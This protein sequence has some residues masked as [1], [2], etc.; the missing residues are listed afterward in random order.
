MDTL[1]AQSAAPTPSLRAVPVGFCRCV[2]ARKCD[3]RKAL[4]FSTSRFGAK[5]SMDQIDSPRPIQ[6]RSNT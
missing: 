3:T 6:K 2:G 1:T 4:D 5:R